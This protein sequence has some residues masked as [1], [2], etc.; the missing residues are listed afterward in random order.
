MITKKILYRGEAAKNAHYYG[1]QADDYYARDNY[2]AVWQ[3]EGARLL[4]LDGQVQSEDFHNMLAGRFGMGVATGNSIRKDSKARAGLDLTISAPKSVTLQALVGDDERVIAAH[5]KAVSETL[6]FIEKN[7]AQSRQTIDGE[8]Y[9]RNTGNLVVAKFRHETARATDNSVP[10]PQLHTHAVIMNVTRREDGSWA[11]LH[12]DQI[13]KMRKL[14]DTVYMAALARELKNLGYEIRHEKNHIELAHISRKQ[15]E[16]FSKR[17]QDISARLQAQGLEK[18]DASHAHRQ[19]ATLATRNT[20]T[21]EF[22]REEL[23]QQWVTQANEVGMQLG[24]ETGLA[25]DRAINTPKQVLDVAS[26]ARIAQAALIWAIKHHSERETVMAHQELVSS[27]LSHAEGLVS[28]KDIQESIRELCVTGKLIMR[29]DRYISNTDLNAEGLTRAAWARAYADEKGIS[30][31]DAFSAVNK[32]IEQ[33]RLSQAPRQYATTKAYEIEKNML[34]M[35]M[36]GRGQCAPIFEAQ[37]L[38]DQLEQSTLTPGQKDTVSLMLNGKNQIVGV[39]GL[40]GTGKS[41][42][43]QQTQKLLN[44]RGYKMIALAPYGT[45]VNNLREDGIEAN[46]VASQLTATETERLQSKLGEKTVVVIDDA[47]VIP[48]R[49]M[50]QL[51]RRLQ[52]SGSRV[53]L[54][55]DTA[56]TKAVEAGRAFALL[57]EQGMETALMGDIQRQKSEHLKKAV[58]L[59]AQ[60]LARE[61]LK[62]IDKVMEVPDRTV[63]LETGEIK[64]AGRDVDSYGYKRIT[65]GNQ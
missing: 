58:E 40:A 30:L 23:Y 25:K 41:Y 2:S 8:N 19:V 24:K 6:E 21:D 17:S 49:Q 63:T 35:E 29:E 9:V 38:S 45:Q 65:Q 51:L 52:P 31:I 27:A 7:L 50:E 22:T 26:R 64:R 14:Q 33:G 57:Q 20:K 61:S 62:H 47:G 46:T 4:G 56:Q 18:I 10:D 15:I 36:Q 5:D 1:D 53:V 43:L 3:G 48:V 54:L 60:G 28:D 59:A 55:G 13:V 11:S 37:E 42:A 16:H 32:A 44:E 39:Q 34:A 12:N